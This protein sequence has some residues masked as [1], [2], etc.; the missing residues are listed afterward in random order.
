MRLHQTKKVLHGKGNNNNN[1]NE[2]PMYRM[3]ENI[4]KPVRINLQN[5]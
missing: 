4:C 1:K 3:R 5:I 2:K